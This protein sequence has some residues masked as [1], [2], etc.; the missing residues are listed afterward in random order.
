MSFDELL[1][2]N[3]YGD[4]RGKK[5]TK[6]NFDDTPSEQDKQKRK[7]DSERRRSKRKRDNYYD[8]DDDD[9]YWQ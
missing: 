4:K 8:D 2:E 6:F 7:K 9:D 1:S 5:P 3:K